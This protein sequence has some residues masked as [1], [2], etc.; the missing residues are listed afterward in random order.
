MLQALGMREGETQG[1]PRVRGSG[2]EA[3]DVSRIGLQTDNHMEVI[4]PAPHLEPAGAGNRWN[5][6]GAAPWTQK[7]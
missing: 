5:P 4:S 3:L 7:M 2:H 6:W 1:L